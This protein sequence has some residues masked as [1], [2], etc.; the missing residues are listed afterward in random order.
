MHRILPA[1]FDKVPNSPFENDVDAET[2]LRVR[3]PHRPRSRYHI[4][5]RF[6]QER[7]A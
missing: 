3:N 1:D 7:L 4:I 5:N 6:V 2:I